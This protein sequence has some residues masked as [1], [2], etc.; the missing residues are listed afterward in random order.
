MK[1]IRVLSAS[2]AEKEEGRMAK[3]EEHGSQSHSTIEKRQ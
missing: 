1:T 2:F 3:Q